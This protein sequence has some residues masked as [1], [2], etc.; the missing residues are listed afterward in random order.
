[1]K[2]SRLF[3]EV[4]VPADRTFRGSSSAWQALL[5]DSW[6]HSG[7]QGMPCNIPAIAGGCPA[8]SIFLSPGSFWSTVNAFTFRVKRSAGA[9][10]P[11]DRTMRSIPPLRHESSVREPNTGTDDPLPKKRIA[12]TLVMACCACVRR[13][14]LVVMIDSCAD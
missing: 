1:M 9:T 12:T 7:L 6:F 13:M 5:S 3:H 11:S 2:N 14:N 10:S 8:K 4:S